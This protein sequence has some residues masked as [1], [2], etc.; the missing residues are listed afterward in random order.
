MKVKKIIAGLMPKKI[1][2]SVDNIKIPCYNGYVTGGIILSKEKNELAKTEQAEPVKLLE[3]NFPETIK[4]FS[5]YQRQPLTGLEHIIGMPSISQGE[6]ME[7]L[8]VYREL[9]L[10]Q[11]EVEFAQSKRTNDRLDALL[12]FLPEFAWLA[13]LLF[14]LVGS[15][16]AACN[17]EFRRRLSNIGKLRLT[18]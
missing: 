12:E 13:V 16:K 11:K 7:A 15:T 17:K 14:V 8:K 18:A 2:V 6:R 1:T 10:K 4:A 9:A 3:I 5:E